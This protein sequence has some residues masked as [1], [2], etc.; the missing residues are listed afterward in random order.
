MNFVGLKKAKDRADFIAWLRLQADSPV[1][2]PSDEAVAAE[3]EL[4]APVIDESVSPA[5]Y[6][7]NDTHH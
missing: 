1:P 7:P 5:P 3:Q 4:L 2:L 6:V